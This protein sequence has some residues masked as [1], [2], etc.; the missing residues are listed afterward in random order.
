[1]KSRA[2]LFA[3]LFASVMATSCGE[4]ITHT[5]VSPTGP[6][7]LSDLLLPRLGGNWGGEL[8]LGGVGGGTGPAV[9]AGGLECTAAAFDKVFG[10]KNDY[11][12]SITQSG[13]DLTAK[14]ISSNTGL[15][16]EYEGRIGSN[17]SFV[18]H[19]ESCTPKVLNFLC[20]NGDGTRTLDLVGSSVT[21]TFD[22][23]INPKVIRGTA[24]YNFNINDPSEPLAA[25]VV[26][27][28]FQSLTRR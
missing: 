21:A 8:T 3:G 10:E 28:S 6:S 25:L 1:M 4:N 7:S 18:L 12:M 26:S 13:S 14:L 27:Q 20:P 24:A 16:C 23:P 9:K 15:A 19:T 17:N 22:D 11:T 5:P 2:A